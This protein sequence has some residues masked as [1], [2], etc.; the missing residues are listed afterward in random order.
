MQHFWSQRIY[1]R[2]W[3]SLVTKYDG[4]RPH[5][6]LTKKTPAAAL[7]KPLPLWFSSC[8]LF[9]TLEGS[10]D[11]LNSSPFRVFENAVWC[12]QLFNF[13]WAGME[14]KITVQKSVFWEREVKNILCRTYQEKEAKRLI[15]VSSLLTVLL[16]KLSWVQTPSLVET[17][18]RNEVCKIGGGW[19]QP[20]VWTHCFLLTHFCCYLMKQVCGYQK[21]NLGCKH[22]LN[23]ICSFGHNEARQKG[24]KKKK[25]KGGENIRPSQTELK[26]K[27]QTLFLSVWS[28]LP[29]LW[30]TGEK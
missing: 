10:G 25:N 23:G 22:W 30:G 13:Q 21:G 1:G 18:A 2:S 19:F 6:F 26:I 14:W 16:Q 20:C 12:Q 5:L 24:L 17:H 9:R 29:V 15:S 7:A 4:N 3:N 28:V 8:C 11:S 27:Q